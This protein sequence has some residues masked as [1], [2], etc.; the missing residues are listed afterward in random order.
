[1]QYLQPPIT[2]S[3]LDQNILFSTTLSY[4]LSQFYSINVGGHVSHTHK[5]TGKVRFI[6]FN[7]YSFREQAREE[8]Q[9]EW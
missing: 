6:R 7:P 3:L 4:T 9:T 5:T 8:L 2:S 1:M